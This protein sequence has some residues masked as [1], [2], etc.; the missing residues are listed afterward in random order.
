MKAKKPMTAKDLLN[1]LL[2]AEKSHD[3]SYVVVFYRHDRDSDIEVIYE[4][5]EDLY[6]E[7]DNQS[8]ESI[9]LLTNGEEV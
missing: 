5:E 9:M 4:A 3:L 7:D 2:E 1:F 6:N 8:L